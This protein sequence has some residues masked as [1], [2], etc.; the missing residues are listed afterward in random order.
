MMDNGARPLLRGF[1]LL[2]ALQS[3]SANAHVSGSGSVPVAGV[4]I[5]EI[6]HGQMPVIARYGSDILALAAWQPVATA[7]FQRVLNYAK[8]QRAY[9]LW[10][11]VP[12]SISDEFSPFNAC[13]H[14][15]LAA[16]RDL[17]LRMTAE[18]GTSAAVD[19]ARRV[20]GDMIASST[21]LEFC[22]FSA[23]PYDTATVVQPVLADM[24]GHP[25]TVA[26]LGGMAALL[27]MAAAVFV[28]WSA[29]AE[30]L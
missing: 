16:M 26:S 7:D 11:L 29:K 3:G 24:V 10:G 15:Y 9:C 1:V 12:G 23:T 22:N 25:A 13:S 21:A 28:R 18:G 2:I 30:V 20:D 4:L 14:A 17:L 8:V 6:T 5:A 19:L 27:I